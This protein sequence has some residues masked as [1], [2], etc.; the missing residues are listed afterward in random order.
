VYVTT[1]VRLY[2]LEHTCAWRSLRQVIIP[3]TIGPSNLIARTGKI[4]QHQL[5]E[6]TPT[7]PWRCNDV[8]I[9]RRAEPAKWSFYARGWIE[10]VI[11]STLPWRRTALGIRSLGLSNLSF[12]LFL[13]VSLALAHNR[14][15]NV[16]VS[17]RRL[18]RRDASYVPSSRLFLFC[19]RHTIVDWG[20][21]RI[22]ERYRI[23]NLK[24]N[25]SLMKI[26]NY[27]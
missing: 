14:F 11:G 19:S 9:R 21:C 26:T 4:H 1:C 25:L 6:L 27:K 3:V 16:D 18:N 23:F 5:D 22:I 8:A 24:S 17:L 13:S 10:F 7:R 20:G 2:T 15:L 12:F